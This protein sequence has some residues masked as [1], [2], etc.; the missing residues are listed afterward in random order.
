MVNGEE[1]CCRP[2]AGVVPPSPLFVS[3]NNSNE[4][5]MVE[6]SAIKEGFTSFARAKNADAQPLCIQQPPFFFL[7]FL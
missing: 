7:F 6:K 5:G 1:K 4:A 3:H 2:R